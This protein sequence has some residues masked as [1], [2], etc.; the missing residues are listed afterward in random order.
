M[1]PSMG[2]WKE[3]RVV[4]SGASSGLGKHLVRALA[5]QSAHLEL[6]A[7][8]Q[9]RLEEVAVQA[10]ADGAASVTTY[11]IDLGSESA[12]EGLSKFRSE[13]QKDGGGI[14]LL[15]NAVG[16]SD[17]GG[18]LQPT[19]EEWLEMFRVNV[20]S[21]VQMIR[22]CQAPLIAA[23]GCV[24]NIGSLA[25]KLAPGGLGAYP[26]VKF[27]LAG[28]SQQ[29][30]QEFLPHGVHVL[31]VCPGPIDRTDAGQRY[32][33]LAETRGLTSSQSLPAGGARLNRI[34][35]EWLSDRILDAA[36]RRRLELI[37]PGK[38]RWLAMLMAICPG[39]A[40]R[41]L[42]NKFPDSH[43]AS[44]VKPSNSVKL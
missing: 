25:S 3:K 26:T 19:D 9:A 33:E 40:E 10:R 5:R 30:R 20:L 43:S 36:E 24:V 4:I 18:G 42:R 15:I 14:D 7:R 35:P 2:Y 16:K 23:K 13:R 44:L 21:S 12:Q 31:L 8:D 1:E 38:V 6:V 11:S 27:A 17:R 39:W 22:A 41:I 34:D 32:S 28:L 37:V 29:L